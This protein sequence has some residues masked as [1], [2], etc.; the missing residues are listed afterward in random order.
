M[1]KGGWTLKIVG[2]SL[3]AKAV[4]QSSEMLNVPTPSR[5]SPL[6]QGIRVRMMKGGWTLKIVGASLLAKAVGQLSEMLNVPTPSRASPLP[7]GF[8][9]E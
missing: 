4:D 1:M 8:A 9:F 2:A 7:Q 6:P 3:L 5:A